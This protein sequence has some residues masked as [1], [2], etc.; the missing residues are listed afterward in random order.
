MTSVQS[1][2]GLEENDYNQ[3]A[4][5]Q[6]KVI[7]RALYRFQTPNLL[8]ACFCLIFRIHTSTGADEVYFIQHVY[9]WFIGGVSIDLFVADVLAGSVVNVTCTT[10]QAVLSQI[11]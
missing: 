5:S 3:C 6:F 1:N 11:Q 2:L 8:F 7:A 10:D 9:R 4:E